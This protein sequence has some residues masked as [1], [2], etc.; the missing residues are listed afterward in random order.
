MLFKS[1]IFMFR[2]MLRGYL[3]LILLIVIPMVLIA[4]LGLLVGDA[5]DTKLGI[6]IIDE[7]AVTMIIIFQLYGG[8]YT[9]EFIRK[10]LLSSTKWRMYSLPYGVHHHAYSII[11]SCTIFSALQ[12]LVMVYFT[13]WIYHVNWGNIGLVILVLFVISI[14]TQLVY[15]N[16]A[17]TVKSRKVTDILAT[18]Y[19]LISIGLAGVWFPMPDI[20]ILNFLSNY[21]NPLSLGRSAIIAS[22]IGGHWELVFLDVGILVAASVVM[23]I[24][25]KF[26]GR[27]K[28]I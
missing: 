3:A 25:A 28:L 1:S 24:V 13:K 8:L 15:L 4:V 23:G 17:I 19:C 10:D 12:G 27:K 22:R 2:R 16:L 26:M 9:M 21:G 18:A 7:I 5:V 14:L 20:G 11:L 6:P